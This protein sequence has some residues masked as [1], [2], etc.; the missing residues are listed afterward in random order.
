MTQ[1]KVSVIFAAKDYASATAASLQKKIT[2][3]ITPAR[4]ATA[5]L[6][7][8]AGAVYAFAAAAKS[9]A[10]FEKRML[11][12]NTITKVNSKQ[13]KIMSNQVLE[14][15][16][17]VPKTADD[18][19]NSLYQIASASIP[20][21]HQ[22]EFL[23][24]SAKAASAGLSETETAADALTTVINAWG[25]SATEVTQVSDVFF[26]TVERG[27]TTF[28]ELA[29]SIAYVAATAADAGISFEEVSAALATLT[30]QGLRTEMSTIALNQAILSILK[31]SKEM[32][33]LIHLAG[34][35]SGKAAF[36]QD[37]MATVL[38]RLSKAATDNGI[39]M[40]DVVNNVRAM[41]A[42]IPLAGSKLQDFKDDLNRM[43]HAAGATSDAIGIQKQGAAYQFQLMTNNIHALKVEVGRELLPAMNDLAAGMVRWIKNSTIIIPQLKLIAHYWGLILGGH[44][45][46]LDEIL[47]WDDADKQLAALDKLAAKY[48]DVEEKSRGYADVLTAITN[49]KWAKFQREELDKIAATAKATTDKA[50]KDG[51]RLAA[52][53]RKRWHEE[54]AANADLVNKRSALEIGY[55]DDTIDAEGELSDWEVRSLK[56]YGEAFAEQMARRVAARQKAA[57]QEVAI[58]ADAQEITL[59]MVRT[60]WA[61]M[62]EIRATQHADEL[63]NIEDQKAALAAYVDYQREAHSSAAE[64]MVG[65]ANAAYGAIEDN[66]TKVLTGQ[67]SLTEGIRDFAKAMLEFVASYLAK[68]V[69]AMAAIA[70]LRKT[71]LAAAAVEGSAT[72][73]ALAAAWAPAAAMASLASFGAN[74]APASLG[75]TS[76]VALTKALTIP[77]MAEGGIVDRPTIALIGESGPEA[78]VPLRGGR[79]PAGKLNTGGDVIINTIEMFPNV[80]TIDLITAIEESP[81]MIDRLRTAMENRTEQLA[82]TGV[83]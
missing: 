15:S 48:A 29:N 43:T 53:K 41:R 7:G 64:F 62:L 22:M 32:A 9:A 83:I 40:R 20:A 24:A 13:F 45:P 31:P 18:L 11:N 54:L 72:A 5:A 68:H 52:A 56:R 63:M 55:V 60:A 36:E 76:T 35:E 70:I 67:K 37:D 66:I 2:G 79:I 82:R 44:G 3:L 46:S 57:E 78:V 6:A 1:Q 19:A 58:E 61:E 38:G 21:A 16:K 8:I 30:R 27:K 25:K 23:E 65:A 10:T 34:Y 75:I 42:I 81:M 73:A 47:T 74:A 80:T 26:K 12:V 14:L 71:G 4:L 49:V 51:E 39:E 69:A 77:A 33:K 28:P 50:I 59:D 17:R